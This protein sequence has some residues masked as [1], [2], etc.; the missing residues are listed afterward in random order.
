MAVL[1]NQL[2][3]EIITHTLSETI[4]LIIFTAWA[5]FSSEAQKLPQGVQSPQEIVELA[6]ERG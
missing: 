2:N 5:S 4:E 1:S 6:A 3:A